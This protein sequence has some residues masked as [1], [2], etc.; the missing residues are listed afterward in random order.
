[1]KIIQAQGQ[2]CNQF[3]IYSNY[4]ADGIENG[5]RIA[6][7]TPDVTMADYP[8]L[9]DNDIV[10][11]PLYLP[12]LAKAIG[13]ERY[14]RLL[15]RI[16]ANRYS[17]WF[18]KNFFRI[19][20]GAEFI[21]GMVGVDMT[22]HRLKHKQELLHIFS[23]APHIRE[24]I[25]RQFAAVRSRR[26]VVV[27]VHIRRGDYKY[28]FDGRYYYTDAQFDSLIRQ[29]NA[30]FGAGDTA[31]FIASDQRVDM[32]AFPN[33]ECFVADN[34]TPTDDWYGLS[35]GDYIIGPP[36]TFSGWASFYGDVPLYQV[37]DMAHQ[38][39]KGNFKHISLYWHDIYY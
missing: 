18:L 21:V 39:E 29:A 12:W 8:A 3:W 27:G 28:A 6:I 26:K 33:V 4:I 1:M 37:E 10:R 15:R 14:L 19:V 38:I 22:H 36:S 32:E 24:R 2:T 16:F 34:P 23:P 7:W 31:F 35:R 11:Y 13:R 20:P 25:E 17:L 9:S 5:D 30:L